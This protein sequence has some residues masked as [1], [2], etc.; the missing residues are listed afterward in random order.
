MMSATISNL[1]PQL[2]AGNQHAPVALHRAGQEPSGMMV[3]APVAVPMSSAIAPAADSFT[4]S[5]TTSD[6][7]SITTPTTPESTEK[8][9]LDPIAL[10][11]GVG[12]SLAAAGLLAATVQTEK[13]EAGKRFGSLFLATG[14][15]VV[16][17]LLAPIG[18]AYIQD[19]LK[20]KPETTATTPDATM[21]P[22][23]TDATTTATTVA[24][25]QPM[26]VNTTSVPTTVAPTL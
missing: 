3:S 18:S 1:A 4:P 12:T 24:G 8:K 9:G 19:L 25:Q 22:A 26:G 17:T 6:G 23:T 11:V 5:A 21:M 2:A 20:K 15:G 16:S 7:T 10:A 14:L 13:E